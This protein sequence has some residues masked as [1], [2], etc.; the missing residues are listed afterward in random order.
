M[1]LTL[2]LPLDTHFTPDSPLPSLQ[3]E[4]YIS[5][6]HTHVMT[7]LLLDTCFSSF[8]IFSLH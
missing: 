6:A 3:F 8:Y 7:R 1:I 4:M 5:L 2:T